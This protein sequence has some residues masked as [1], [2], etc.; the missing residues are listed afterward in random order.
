MPEYKKQHWLSK[1]YLKNFVI[2]G[3]KLIYRF[4]GNRCHKVPYK[5]QCFKKHFYSSKNCREAEK[6]FWEIE[7]DFPKYIM[8]ILN[9]KPISRRERIDIIFILFIYHLRTAAFENRT[10]YEN[11]IAFRIRFNNFFALEISELDEHNI[12]LDLRKRMEGI[13]K[14][15]ELQMIIIHSDILI[16]S[17]HPVLLFNKREEPISFTILPITPYKLLIAYDRRYIKIK[18]PL[19]DEK[20]RLMLNNFQAGQSLFAIYSNKV[21]NEEEREKYNEI[22]KKFRK[23]HRGYTDNKISFIE[24]II[25]KENLSFVEII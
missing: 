3:S 10:D 9:Y 25:Y 19:S 17:D 24:T 21:I 15:W 6:E 5:S 13:S 8:K 7:K 22:F 1:S 14:N 2:N 11:I 20:D 23:Q 4:D 12:D 18:P 16:T